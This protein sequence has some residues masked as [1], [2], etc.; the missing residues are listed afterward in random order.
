MQQQAALMAAAA[1]GAYLTPMAALTAA[2][3]QQV[4]AVNMNG[5]VATPITPASGEISAH[6]IALPQ[7]VIRSIIHSCIDDTNPIR[8]YVDAQLPFSCLVS[9]D[10]GLDR[11]SVA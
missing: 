1:H 7:P 8:W 5:L 2:Q 10:L 11:Q 9:L 6:S 3:M 4:A